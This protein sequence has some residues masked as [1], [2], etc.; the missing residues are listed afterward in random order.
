M[1]E[2][3]EKLTHFPRNIQVLIGRYSSDITS[4]S[5]LE[6]MEYQMLLVLC[7]PLLKIS[8]TGA[9]ES[10]VRMKRPD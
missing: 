1:S 3:W 9:F 4:I 10:V 8:T 6:I 5:H 7:F 2:A